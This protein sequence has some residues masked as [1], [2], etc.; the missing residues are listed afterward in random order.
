MRKTI[1][2]VF[3]LA[4]L[5]CIG[6]LAL[7]KELPYWV[8]RAEY[9]VP[10]AAPDQKVEVDWLYQVTEIR[11]IGG[12]EWWVVTVESVRG[13]A[14]SSGS[15][16]FQP[17]RRIVRDACCL[18]KRNGVEMKIDLE[19]IQGNGVSLHPYS[20]FPL[21]QLAPASLAEGRLAAR[22]S[23]GDGWS[24]QTEFLVRPGSAEELPPS[25]LSTKASQS[26]GVVSTFVVEGQ[27]GSSLSGRRILRYG[28]LFPWWVCCET[29][30]FR[31]VMI[32]CQGVGLSNE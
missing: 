32:E 13:A 15:F 2:I 11:V 18:T 16:L 7:A 31:A 22:S 1:T 6:G 27:K 4:T 3:I 26:V 9:P 19:S 23:G 10:T 20:P 8:V 24:Y 25:S 28:S 12:E 5:F 29:S 30:S 17:E 14:V 21:D